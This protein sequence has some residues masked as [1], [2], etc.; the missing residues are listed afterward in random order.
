MRNIDKILQNAN[1]LKINK[2]LLSEEEIRRIV[3]NIPDNRPKFVKLIRKIIIMTVPIFIVFIGLFLS[4]I[5]H[6]TNQMEK[7]NPQIQKNNQIIPSREFNDSKSESIDERFDKMNKR[8]SNEEK[9]TEKSKKV[10]VEFKIVSDTTKNAGKEN[11]A[12]ESLPW[13]IEGMTILEL[14][15]EEFEKL[16]PNS[17]YDDTTFYVYTEHLVSNEKYFQI[18]TDKDNV[19]ITDSL[20]NKFKTSDLP[21]LFLKKTTLRPSIWRHGNEVASI[22]KLNEYKKTLYVAYS[23]TDH[24]MGKGH[25]MY[26]TSEPL[27]LDNSKDSFMIEY[28]D[29]NRNLSKNLYNAKK[30]QDTTKYLQLHQKSKVMTN[31]LFQNLVPVKMEIYLGTNFIFWFYPN[32]EFLSAI[33][34]RY[35][36][37]LKKELEI[38]RLVESGVLDIEEACKGLDSEGSIFG[39]CRMMNGAI[40]FDNL[41]PNPDRELTKL[42]FTLTEDRKLNIRIYDLNG[43]V[44][45]ELVNNKL[46]ETGSHEIDIL[47]DKLSVGINYL[48]IKTDANETIVK[49]LIKL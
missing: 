39:L 6:S 4:G 15:Y 18:F 28:V 29:F 25:A 12:L 13:K 32:E 19:T 8:I 5:E 31:T 46:Y 14:S 44:I 17:R 36:E 48:I 1:K 42:S 35:S 16:V 37:N 27:L 24:I 47:M 22:T 34:E 40:K 33:P 9:E 38:K 11:K 45:E 41:F 23:T 2:E 20:A 3:N 10:Q 7:A 26:N 49:R 30:E 21:L 43:K